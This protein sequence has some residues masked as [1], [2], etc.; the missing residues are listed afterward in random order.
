[1]ARALLALLLGYVVQA[2]VVGGIDPEILGKGVEN[3]VASHRC[4]SR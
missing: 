3:L 1:M 4:A 2:V